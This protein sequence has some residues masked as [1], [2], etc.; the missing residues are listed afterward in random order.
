MPNRILKLKKRQLQLYTNRTDHL[1]IVF[2]LV[3]TIVAFSLLDRVSACM[4]LSR[5]RQFQST[6]R[7]DSVL[8]PNELDFNKKDHFPNAGSRQY[9]THV[10]FITGYTL[11]GRLNLI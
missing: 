4:G 3:A 9:L 6:F 10:L 1:T 5:I 2:C 7:S 11:A 8:S